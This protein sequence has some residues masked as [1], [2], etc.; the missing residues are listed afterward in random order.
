MNK[1]DILNVIKDAEEK[2]ERIKSSALQQKE[3]NLAKAK[4]DANTKLG[5]GKARSKVL[6]DN[7]MEKASAQITQEK[8]IIQA[9]A[10]KQVDAM[11]SDA[12][13]NID[14]ASN[15]LVREFERKANGA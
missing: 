9:K 12:G 2:A 14:Q 6:Y 13:T 5:E 4:Q 10:S 11:R 7:M 15:F 1:A 8:G 3:K